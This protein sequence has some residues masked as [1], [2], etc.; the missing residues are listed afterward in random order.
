MDQTMGL[1]EAIAENTEMG[2]NTLEQILKMTDD[3]TLSA[4]LKREQEYYHDANRRAHAAM[5]DIGGC[6]RGQT[7][8]AKAMTHMGICMETIKDKS[9]RK[10]AEMLIEGSNQGV[11]DC[12]KAVSDYPQASEQAVAL[13]KELE[14]FQQDSIRRLKKFLG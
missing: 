7:K 12:V 6:V 5:A 2:K 11:I 8:W 13:A 4:E 1:L 10:L 9:T 3:A 14:D